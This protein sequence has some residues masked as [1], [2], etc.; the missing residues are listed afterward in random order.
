MHMKLVT[1][2]IWLMSHGNLSCCVTYLAN[3]SR[4]YRVTYL[5]D[6]HSELIEVRVSVRSQTKF[7]DPF[8][9]FL[10]PLKWVFLIRLLLC[11][12]EETN[13]L[14]ENKNAQTQS[15]IRENNLIEKIL[16]KKAIICQCVSVICPFLCN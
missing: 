3:L 7:A 6:Q 12:L 15:I 4:S 8:V 13:I 9:E 10:R 5:A 11:F 16:L 14:Q 2:P 1:L